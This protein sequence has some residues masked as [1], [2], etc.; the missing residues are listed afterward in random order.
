MIKR[1][2]LVVVGVFAAVAVVGFFLQ[3]DAERDDSGQVASEGKLSVFDLRVGDCLV[4]IA[5]KTAEQR[6]L[7]AVPCSK[8]HDGEVYTNIDLGD[9]EFPGDE[10]VAGKAERGCA[11][12]LRRQ[13]PNS[14]AEILYFVPN[15]RTW[16]EED[17]RTVTCIAEYDK[18]RKGT[19]AAMSWREAHSRGR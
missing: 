12:R 17:D 18:P 10:F 1:I 5:S 3:D 2:V 7:E 19:V 11:A 15:K 9:G 13:A 8:L 4:D 6:D 14:E 16:D